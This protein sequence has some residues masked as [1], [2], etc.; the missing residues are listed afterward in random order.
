M[1][2]HEIER[3]SPEDVVREQHRRHKGK[4]LTREA[5]YAYRKKPR[6]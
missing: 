3:R 4:W 6:G 2:E 5:A 1:R